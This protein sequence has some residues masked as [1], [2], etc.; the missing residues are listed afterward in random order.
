MY[1]E[2]QPYTVFNNE[3][4]FVWREN[5]YVITHG[6]ETFRLPDEKILCGKV[7][8]DGVSIRA[9][10]HTSFPENGRR[11]GYMQ[12]LEEFFPNEE[13]GLQAISK[14]YDPLK[15]NL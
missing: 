13:M 1:A 5:G 10:Y 6:S 3:D 8:F 4:G 7:W 2:C 15:D 9:A 12:Y 14:T 11:T